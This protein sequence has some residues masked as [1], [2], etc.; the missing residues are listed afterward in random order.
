MWLALRGLGLKTR[1]DKFIPL[2]A[3]NTGARLE[4]I[5]NGEAFGS[6]ISILWQQFQFLRFWGFPPKGL[7]CSE[8]RRVVNAISTNTQVIKSKGKNKEVQ[9]EHR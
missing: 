3:N 6:N 7:R 1:E 5:P 8:K 4:S 2:N 9:Y